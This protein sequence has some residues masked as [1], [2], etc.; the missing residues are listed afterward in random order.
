MI[1]HTFIW[2]QR[3]LNPRNVK[4]LDVLFFFY[5]TSWIFQCLINVSVF[6]ILASKHPR[7]DNWHLFAIFLI[8]ILGC[9][10]TLRNIKHLFEL[11][12]G[13][14]R[15]FMVIAN[16]LPKFNSVVTRTRVTLNMSFGKQIELFRPSEGQL[17]WPMFNGT[18]A[19]ICRSS[20]SRFSFRCQQDTVLN[21]GWSLVVTDVVLRQSSDYR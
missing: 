16:A 4:R 3:Y 1:S 17:C 9:Y 10:S 20:A 2:I 13:Q 18:L 12:F 15:T 11:F 7:N 8:G 5:R 21:I 6:Y 14:R 19:K